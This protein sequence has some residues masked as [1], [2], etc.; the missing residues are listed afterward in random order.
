MPLNVDAAS[1]DWV[2]CF[3]RGKQAHDRHAMHVVSN[4]LRVRN[5]MVD[6]TSAFHAF[7]VAYETKRMNASLGRRW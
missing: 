5:P 6:P 4:T 1:S 2:V 3:A 7:Q